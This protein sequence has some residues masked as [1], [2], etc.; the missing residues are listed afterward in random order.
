MSI[1]RHVVGIA[2]E[3]FTT[4]DPFDKPVTPMVTG[5]H[6]N[7]PTVLEVTANNYQEAARFAEGQTVAGNKPISIVHIGRNKWEIRTE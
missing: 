4:N 3:L 7:S 2:A 6:K 5:T 1:W